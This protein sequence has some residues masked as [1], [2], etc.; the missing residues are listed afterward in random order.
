MTPTE[1][2]SRLPLPGRVYVKKDTG[3]TVLILGVAMTHTGVQMV[4]VRAKGQHGSEEVTMP[5]SRLLAD[6]N[7][8][9]VSK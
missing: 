3:A 2:I 1:Q 7:V 6:F 5:L 8:M 9:E 4:S